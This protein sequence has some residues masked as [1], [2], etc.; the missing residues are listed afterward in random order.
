VETRAQYTWM[1]LLPRTNDGPDDAGDT[2]GFYGYYARGAVKR[3]LADLRPTLRIGDAQYV[4]VGAEWSRDLERSSSVSVSEFG[5]Y[6][7][8]LR[9]ARENRALYAQALGER[10]RL[11][12]TIGA[13][14]DANSAFGSFQTARVG[15][16][17]RVNDAL[18]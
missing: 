6:P 1:D 2:L 18:R 9:A 15:A 17:W 10:G 8:T 7:D 4:T 13:R 5:D 11:S 16:G 14:L 12:Y 3:R